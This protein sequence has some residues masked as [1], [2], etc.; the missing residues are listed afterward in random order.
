MVLS[1]IPD[2]PRWTS[3]EKAGLRD[4]IAAKAGKTEQRYIRLLQQHQRLREAI[5]RL[6][7]R[8]S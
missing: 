6:G 5:L 4:M 3:E 1:L 8:I 2:L 7:S